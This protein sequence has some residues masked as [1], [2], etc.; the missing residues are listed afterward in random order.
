M[1]VPS[2]QGIKHVKQTQVEQIGEKDKSMITV[3]HVNIPLST[4]E[5]QEI[6]KEY[7]ELNSSINHQGLIDI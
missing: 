1:C 2:N 5:R 6:K 3:G 4:V 7:T